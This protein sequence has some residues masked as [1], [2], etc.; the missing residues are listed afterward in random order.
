LKKCWKDVQ[1][2]CLKKKGVFF[3]E[4][5]SNVCWKMR[6]QN[7]SGWCM[8]NFTWNESCP[9]YFCINNEIQW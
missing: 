4:I 5:L 1:I 6:L 8:R 3:R 9:K 2:I 7:R